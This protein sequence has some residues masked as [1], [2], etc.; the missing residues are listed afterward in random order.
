MNGLLSFGCFLILLYL[1]LRHFVV[2]KLLGL[3]NPEV[4]GQSCICNEAHS[5]SH[6]WGA[7]ETGH[8]C[9]HGRHP[10]HTL[11]IEDESQ[12]RARLPAVFDALRRLTRYGSVT[13][14]VGDSKSDFS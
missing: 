1:V 9:C 12:G 2:E 11:P 3:P 4:Q 6:L 8:R 14:C 7:R 5:L 10:E 13:C